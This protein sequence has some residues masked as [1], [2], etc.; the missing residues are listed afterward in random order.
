MYL[1]VCICTRC[2]TQNAVDTGDPEDCS[3]PVITG[4]KCRECGHIIRPDLY[5]EID[6]LDYII[7]GKPLSYYARGN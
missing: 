5:E 3:A 4:I 1:W 2:R 6:E 7:T